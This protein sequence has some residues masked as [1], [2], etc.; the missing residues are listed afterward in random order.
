MI[1]VVF[2]EKIDEAGAC[3]LNFGDRLVRRQRAEQGVGQFARVLARRLGQLH[4]DVAGEI[5]VL[6]I[7]GALDL[8]GEITLSG[9]YQGVGQ[10]CQGAA[11]Q[12]F[13][14]GLQCGSN[15]LC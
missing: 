6:R 14:Q 9:G 15:W 12:G 3:D 7:A 8:D 1:G 13:D 2:Q 5:A 10:R 11:Q 4:R